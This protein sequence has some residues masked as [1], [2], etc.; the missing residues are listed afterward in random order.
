MFEII[1]NPSAKYDPDGLAGIVNI[2]T[3]KRALDG[4]SGLINLSLGYAI[5]TGEMPF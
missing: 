2:V 4:I 3:K 5:N 1:T